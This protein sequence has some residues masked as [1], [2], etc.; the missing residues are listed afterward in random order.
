MIFFKYF[1]LCK[2][3]TNVFRNSFDTQLFTLVRTSVLSKEIL[4]YIDEKNITCLDLHIRGAGVAL[5]TV[6][7]SIHFI[8]GIFVEF[9]NV[10]SNSKH[11]KQNLLLDGT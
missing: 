8:D 6:G 3:I 2:K 1:Q 11:I 5:Q 9:Q 7:L 10:F 4:T